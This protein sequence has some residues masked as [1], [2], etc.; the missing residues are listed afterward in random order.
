[1]ETIVDGI[2]FNNNKVLFI[3]DNKVLKILRGKLRGT[4][5]ERTNFKEGS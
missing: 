1:M 2:I 3:K 4:K 5:N